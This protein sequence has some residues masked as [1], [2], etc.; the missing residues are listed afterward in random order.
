MIMKF[1]QRIYQNSNNYANI[2][3][4]KSGLNTGLSN[5]ALTL[6]KDFYSYKVLIQQ[7]TDN[8]IIDNYFEKLEKEA[9]NITNT[10]MDYVSNITTQIQKSLDIIYEGKKNSWPKIRTSINDIVFKTLDDVFNE[11]FADLKNM[12][13]SFNDKKQNLKVEPLD[14]P[15]PDPDPDVFNKT[16]NTII[17]N[18]T[19]I[20]YKYGYSLKKDG[21]YNFK[22]DVYTEG[23]ITLD[24]IQ[25]VGERLIEKISGK[26][27]SGTIGL[28]ANYTLHNLGVDYEA[29]A[30]LNKVEYTQLVDSDKYVYFNTTRSD[31]N[32][33]I[34]MKKKIRTQYFE[35]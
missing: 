14:V 32:K 33:E 34:N 8:S 28:N 11:K 1:F 10:T 4:I 18:I 29:Y 35:E 25:N 30:Y 13:E 5:D 24:I 16:L 2:V 27:G 3:K 19:D 9:E 20:N 21:D 26:L 15:N 23:D 12:S 31:E 6:T 7:Y 17:F 22:L